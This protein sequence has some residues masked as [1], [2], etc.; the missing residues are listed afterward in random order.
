MLL[1]NKLIYKLNAG[2]AAD[3]DTKVTIETAKSMPFVTLTDAFIAKTKVW[4]I[5][6]ASFPDPTNTLFKDDGSGS[7]A[8]IFIGSVLSASRNYNYI[9]YDKTI[10]G[11]INVPMTDDVDITN[12]EY[13]DIATTAILY[14]APINVTGAAT[15]LYLG[16]DNYVKLPEPPGKLTNGKVLGLSVQ[17]IN[18]SGSI[19][20]AKYSDTPDIYEELNMLYLL[21][22][23]ASALS[24]NDDTP[25]YTMYSD[26][27]FTNRL[28]YAGT[29]APVKIYIPLA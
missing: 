15:S 5:D 28:R 16:R 26:G 7:N 12:F 4:E 27:Q 21:E 9:Y 25:L 1:Q 23:D 2:V 18:T 22:V 19:S 8:L 29:G 14:P 3:T 13:R 6:I 11:Y 20:R 24:L 10:N 17:G